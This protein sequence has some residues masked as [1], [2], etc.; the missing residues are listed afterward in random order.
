[1]HVFKVTWVLIRASVVTW[2]SPCAS[3]EAAC[4]RNSLSLSLRAPKVGPSV[5][6][7]KKRAIMVR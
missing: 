4:A 6:N 7:E 2:A 3:L 1:M 5:P